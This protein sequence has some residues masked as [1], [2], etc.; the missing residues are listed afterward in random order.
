MLTGLAKAFVDFFYPPSCVNCKNKVEE[1]NTLCQ[2]C[3]D[4]AA[5]A[6]TYKAGEVGLEHLDAIVVL[7]RYRGGFQDLLHKVKFAGHKE[8]LQVL[9]EEFVILW[10]RSGGEAV[11]DILCKKD[12]TDGNICI[13]PVP[14]DEERLTKRGYDLPESIFKDWSIEQNFSFVQCLTRVK[15]TK[16][17]YELDGKERRQNMTGAI[18]AVILPEEEI[19]IIADDILTTGATLCECA[20]AL[21]AAGAYDKTIIGLTLASD[22]QKPA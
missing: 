6:R 22:M 8:L 18:K 4:G 1:S 5:F 10:E 14:T 17:Q 2:N 21:R 12:F 19:L 16:P 9:R 13:I 7:A 11:R 3:R 20:R 15:A